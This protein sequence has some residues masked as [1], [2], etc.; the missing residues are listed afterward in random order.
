MTS[1]EKRNLVRAAF[2]SDL[3]LW[4]GPYSHHNRVTARF[5]S[6][7][8]PN[9]LYL[10]LQNQFPHYRITIVPSKTMTYGTVGYSNVVGTKN[11]WRVT[12]YIP[13]KEACPCS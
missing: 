4:G 8:K 12:V 3:T 5:L 10:L 13:V 7:Y 6:K 9:K 1:K 11:L 2:R